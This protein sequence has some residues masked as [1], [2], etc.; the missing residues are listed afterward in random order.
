VNN[1][2]KQRK[3]ERIVQPKTV[4]VMMEDISS[5]VQ[6]WAKE[7][8]LQSDILSVHGLDITSN[9]SIPEGKTA[10]I[11]AEPEEGEGKC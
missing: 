9:E 4:Q 2:E 3:S 6:Q 7:A 8:I 11:T 10:K 5:Q 1:A